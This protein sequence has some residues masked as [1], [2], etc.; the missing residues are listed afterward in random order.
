L[1][2]Q[3]GKRGVKCLT[4]GVKCRIDRMKCRMYGRVKSYRLLTLTP[5]YCINESIV[6][7]GVKCRGVKSRRVKCRGV[8]YR[9][10]KSRTPLKA[11]TVRLKIAN[12]IL[13]LIWF[14]II[15]VFSTLVISDFAMKLK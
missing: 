1:S 13:V 4:L 8:K 10:V 14:I 12:L 3:S 7:S 11:I 2:Y 6:K 9:G 5:L 15:L